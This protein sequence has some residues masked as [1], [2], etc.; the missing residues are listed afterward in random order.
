MCEEKLECHNGALEHKDKDKSEINKDRVLYLNLIQDLVTRFANLGASVKNWMVTVLLGV[1]SYEVKNPHE[2]FW[3][4]NNSVFASFFVMSLYYHRLEEQYIALYNY[5]V[6][7]KNYSGYIFIL[8]PE[9]FLE[10]GI[11]KVTFKESLTVFNVSFY[12]AV[13]L[14]MNLIYFLLSSK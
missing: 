7:D 13:F 12:I 4:L 8:S 3:V 14:L 6:E 5:V 1:I 2:Y 10:K 11:R 9:K